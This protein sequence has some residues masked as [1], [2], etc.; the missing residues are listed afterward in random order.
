MMNIDLN[1]LKPQHLMS[2]EDLTEENRMLR[3]YIDQLEKELESR[4]DVFQAGTLT[5]VINEQKNICD[6]EVEQRPSFN[7]LKKSSNKMAIVELTLQ[8]KKYRKVFG[9]KPASR[10]IKLNLSAINELN[11]MNAQ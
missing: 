9:E 11:K 7:G 1:N 4:A 5:D 10:E 2:K 6:N 3:I 8:Y